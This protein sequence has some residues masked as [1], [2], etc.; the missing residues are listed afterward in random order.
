M[1][2][3]FDGPKVLLIV[4][5]KKYKLPK[6]L[7][8]RSSTFLSSAF[9][10]PFKEGETQELM[11]KDTTAD[12][13]ELVIQW[14]Y[15]GNLVLPAIVQTDTDAISRI[16]DFLNAADF[17]DLDGNPYPA[18]VEE[19][20]ARLIKSREALNSAHIIKAMALP[21]E[22]TT[23]KVIMQAC[24]GLYFI[25]LGASWTYERHYTTSMFPFKF[26]KELT[27]VDGFAADLFRLCDEVRR[28]KDSSWGSVKDPLTGSTIYNA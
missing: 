11:L 28:T 17:L 4:G 7:A 15:T 9:N 12:A 3:L 19:L 18:V 13:F 1:L 2:D 10:G 16:L 6:R 20:K 5:A 24:I 23:R 25:S 26:D 22:H 27:Q 21:S 8:C 14:I